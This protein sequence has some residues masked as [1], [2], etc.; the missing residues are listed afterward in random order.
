M[1][2]IT[3]E[4]FC[5]QITRH[6]RESACGL[7]FSFAE[8]E[9]MAGQ[10]L[11]DKLHHFLLFYKEALHAIDYHVQNVYRKLQV[12]TLFGAISKAI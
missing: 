7:H 12:N 2:E 11:M 6:C 9:E 10:I 3:K 5:R 8:S 4:D 1:I